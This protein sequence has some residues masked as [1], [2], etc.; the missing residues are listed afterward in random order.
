M[1]LKLNN[2]YVKWGLTLF[3]VVAASICFYYLIFHAESLK[4]NI[5]T[6]I[7]VMMP[8]M[9]GL[10]MGYLLAPVLNY[11]EGKIIYPFC[12]KVGIKENEK[13]RKV[14]RGI[15]I[16]ITSCLFFFTVYALIA[17]MLSQ[18]VP[19]IQNIINNFD[20]YYNNIIKW[21]EELFENNPDLKKY[22]TK[23]INKYSAELELWLKDTVL[24]KTS[25]IIKTISISVI[26]T[27]S[28][29]WNYIIGFIISIYVLGC[30]EKFAG[31]A[32]K[33]TYALFS[34]ETANIVINNF[35]FTHKTFIGFVGGKIVDSMII[36]ILCFIGTTLLKTPYAVLVS[37]IIG[38]T[39]V[40]PF[41]GPFLGAIPTSILIFVVDP[42]H[43]LNCVYFIIFIFLL[44]QFDGNILG[45]KILGNSTGITGFWVIF[46]IT[47][48]GG[49]FGVLGMIIAVPL[50]AVLYAMIKSYVNASL[51]KKNL[52]ED[53]DVYIKA[54]SF[55]EDGFHEYVPDLKKVVSLNPKN[56]KSLFFKKKRKEAPEEQMMPKNEYRVCFGDYFY[57]S[58]E[59][60]KREKLKYSSENVK[61]KDTDSGNKARKGNGFSQ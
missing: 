49:I 61:K 60:L 15:G 24:T 22:L 14:V 11:I 3:L 58:E 21:L 28:I 54:G 2:K 16:L 26:S 59:D 45:P 33:I 48:F 41:F 44:Q 40:I 43:P 17:M 25:E 23:S 8:V 29:L 42:A 51:R 31:Q 13:S 50:F 55:D 18:I 9:F 35:R 34:K 7:N 27:L 1:K 5:L 39:N 6:A 10:V 53:T 12:K 46:S 19:S 36:G 52:T 57:G 32:K 30:K 4:E 38:F 56:K 20:V 37:V 47:V